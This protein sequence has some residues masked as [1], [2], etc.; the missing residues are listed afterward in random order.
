[1]EIYS[2]SLAASIEN[3][4]DYQAQQ[5]KLFPRNTGFIVLD[6][7]KTKITRT[8]RE[9]KREYKQ[10]ITKITVGVGEEALLQHRYQ[11][12]QDIK[13]RKWNLKRA[14]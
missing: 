8:S 13:N 4:S 7:G 2:H 5:E 10:D 1:M 6:K 9:A 11:V 14:A 3:I 12:L